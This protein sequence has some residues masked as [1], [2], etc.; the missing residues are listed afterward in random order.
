ML[1]GENRNYN[2]RQERIGDRKWDGQGTKGREREN[3]KIICQNYKGNLRVPYTTKLRKLKT[4][5]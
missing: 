4:K 5:Y 2:H 1:P 3:T